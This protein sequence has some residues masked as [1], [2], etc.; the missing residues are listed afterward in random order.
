[1][2]RLAGRQVVKSRPR[3]TA[4]VA[5][6]LLRML[7][8]LTDQPAYVLDRRWNVLCWNQ[9][10]EAVFGDY[11]R[12]AQE[13][14]NSMYMLFNN[15]E[16]RELLLEWDKLAPIALKMFRSENAAHAEDP[17]YNCLVESLTSVSPDFRRLWLQHEVSSYVSINKKI[18]HP[19]AGR[20]TFEYNS[21][22]ADDQSDLKLVVY[23]PLEEHSTQRK[24][25]DLLGSTMRREFL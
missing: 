12:L 4:E 16:H 7:H 8:S 17:D 6:P 14:R 2:F 13:E 24:V 19:I 11:S 23:T 3:A 1:M 22:T 18:K 25:R 20:M 10:A 15:P 9:P 21:F 5:Q